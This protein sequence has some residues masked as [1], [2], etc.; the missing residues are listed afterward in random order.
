MDDQVSFSYDKSLAGYL[1]TDDEAY[2]YQAAQFGKD[3]MKQ[4]IGH[5]TILEM[6]F[7]ALERINKDKR[8]YPKETIDKSFTV[9]MEGVM[10]YG[11]AHQEYLDS[12]TEGYLAE[13][14][15]LNRKL[16][17]KLNETT[18]LYQTHSVISSILQLSLE[19]IPLDELLKRALEFILSVSWFTTEPRGS[20]FLVEGDL[21]VLVMK[22]Q[23]GLDEAVQKE[24]ERVQFGRCLCGKAALTQEIQF[25]DHLDDSHETTHEVMTPHGH[26][27]VPILYAGRTLGVLCLYLKEGHRL[28]ET[29][30]EFLT[31]FAN[32]LA[33]IITRREMEESMSRANRALRTLSGCNEALIRATEESGLFYE[34]CRIIVEEGGYR[35]AWIGLAEQD[36][37]KTVRPVAQWGYEDGYLKTVNITWADNERGRGPTGSAIRTGKPCIAKDILTDPNFLPWRA[38]AVRRGYVSAI[39]VPLI[40]NGQAIGT[41]NIYAEKPDAFDE[42]EVAL[43]AELGNDVAYGIMALRNQAERKQAEEELVKSEQRYRTIFEESI[44]AIAIT[45]R[46][47]KLLDVNQAVLDLL[48]YSRNEIMGMNFRE[49]YVE[50]SAGKRFQQEIDQKGYVSN[51]EVKLRKKDGAELDC[52]FTVSTKRADDGSIV[53]YQGFIRDITDR[54]KL[55]A[56]FLQAQKMEVIGRLAGGMAHDFNNLLTI[57]I[58]NAD[59]MSIGLSKDNPLCENIEEIKKAVNSSAYLIQ[60]LLAFSRKQLVQPKVLNLNEVLRETEKML[61]RLI[62]EDVELKAIFEPEIGQVKVDPGQIEQVIINLAV[63]ARDAMSR[64]GKLTIETVNVDLDENYFHDHG[65]KNPPGPYVMLAVSDTGIGI[66]K[67]TQSRI[68]EP[69]FT[70]KEKGRGTG[71]GLAT[72]YGIIKQAGGYIWVYSGPGGGTTFKIYLPRVEEKA[73]SVKKEIIPMDS[74]RGS[75]TILVVEDDDALRNLA[76]EILKQSGYTV[77]EASNGEEALVVSE[78]HEGAIHLMITD[79][80]MPGMNGGELAERLRPLQSETKML[81]MSGHTVNTIVHHGILD[82]ALEFLQKPFTLEV[83][84]RKVREVLDKK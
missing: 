47:G 76:L 54:K 33:R 38:E 74:L 22:A 24:C 30:A 9:L 12:R 16:S 29:E 46:E 72:V 13:I 75:E 4:G 20:I 43:L 50:P 35:L 45:S 55:E 17:K 67:R 81:Y 66:D 5:E 82:S 79:V 62:G 68:F 32:I 69:F 3:L 53:G 71:L 80:V 39:A 77:L 56:Q 14:R 63:N 59:L 41:I 8:M 27:G 21:E 65:V 57:I 60:Q 10:A 52:L 1:R 61:R 26:Y 6:H 83:L 18:A 58:G 42:E 36:E 15:E 49:L 73:E 19:N 40:T 28:D 70:T 23:I 78:Q 64:G 11:M 31:T 84:V 37:N 2:L 7:K 34:I 51:F 44:D 25:V 48:G